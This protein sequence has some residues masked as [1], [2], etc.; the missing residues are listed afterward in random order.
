M[1]KTQKR[2]FVAFLIIEGR[3]FHTEMAR[4]ILEQLNTGV[5]G[6]YQMQ[7]IR[8]RNDEKTITDV[9]RSVIFKRKADVIICVGELCSL[10]V[11][12]VISDLFSNLPVLFVGVSDPVSLGLLDSL[13]SK[14]A[15]M[16]GIV[17]EKLDNLKLP[18]SFGFFYPVVQSVLIPYLASKP[19]LVLRVHEIERY[20]TALGMSVLAMPILERNAQMTLSMIHNY[21]P[22]VQ[23][24][25]LLEGCFSIALQPQLAYLCWERQI[26]LCGSGPYAIDNGTACSLAGDLQPIAEALYTKLRLLWEYKV[27][28]H[29]LPVTVLPN[30]EEFFVNID[31]LR[32]YDIPVVDIARI[33]SHPGVRIVRRWTKPFRI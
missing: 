12:S 4:L 2:C 33:C 17:R 11:K 27:P 20:L 19:Y 28:I 23:G 6:I 10:A 8:I 29:S 21:L 22:R 26:I 25:I 14:E 24:I 9:V 13:E 1:G 31:T 5:Q 7:M 30:N 32:R 16:T 3:P 18:Q 15:L